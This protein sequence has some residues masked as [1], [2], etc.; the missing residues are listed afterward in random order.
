MLGESAQ[1]SG[2]NTVETAKR[3]HRE[4]LYRFVTEIDE[5]SCHLSKLNQRFSTL[6]IPE[7]FLQMECVERR[8]LCI[9][10]ATFYSSDLNGE[11]MSNEVDDIAYFLRSHPDPPNQRKV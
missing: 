1:D 4:A 9:S 10:F 5:R 6:L 2:L 7:K 8:E 11:E 3:A